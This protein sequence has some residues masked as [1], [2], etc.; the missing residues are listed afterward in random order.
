MMLEGQLENHGRT[1]NAAAA[2]PTPIASTEAM[3]VYLVLLWGVLDSLI[4]CSSDK[5]L[6][7][8][9]DHKVIEW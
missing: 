6:Q 2:T 5:V 8:E 7:M 9:C 4:D 1:R 3:L